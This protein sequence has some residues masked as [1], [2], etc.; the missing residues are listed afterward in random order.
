MHMAHIRRA[1]P[2]LHPSFHTTP[3]ALPVTMWRYLATPSP[4][5]SPHCT[6]PHFPPVSCLHLPLCHAFS[7]IFSMAFPLFFPGQ[8]CPLPPLH[9][10]SSNTKTPCAP[11]HV[12][13]V[14]ARPSFPPP[15]PRVHFTYHQNAGPL[16]AVHLPLKRPF[17]APRPPPNVGALTLPLFPFS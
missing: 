16:A 3:G 10:S 5:R 1:R 4:P 6:P 13:S 14:V 7:P 17:F 12:D 2:R 8:H 11:P 15:H 9:E